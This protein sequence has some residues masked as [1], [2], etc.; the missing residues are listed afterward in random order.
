MKGG[1]NMAENRN[2]Y[3]AQYK[4]EKLKRVPLD[5]KKN[6]YE[7]LQEAAAKTGEPVNTYIKNAI[8]ARIQKAAAVSGKTPDE[9]I[10]DAVEAQ[11]TRDQDGEN[12]P[13]GLMNNLIIWL[14]DHGHTVNEIVDC[15]ESINKTK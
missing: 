12:I 8:A 10:H 6:D 7:I 14:K 13:Q 4:C 2:E 1:E 5:M 9:Y 3:M 15:I 11:I